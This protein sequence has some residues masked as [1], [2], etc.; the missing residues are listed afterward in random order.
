MRVRDFVAS[1][2]ARPPVL[3]V[4]VRPI[5]TQTTVTALAF[6]LLVAVA[7]AVLGQGLE[8][9]LWA[10]VGTGVL[11]GCLVLYLA[12]RLMLPRRLRLD[13]GWLRI[14]IRR[15]ETGRLSNFRIQRP[16][17]FPYVNLVADL[18]VDGRDP[19]SDGIPTVAL[20]IQMTERDAEALRTMVLAVLTARAA[21]SPS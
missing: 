15:W 3:D 17:G 14:G 21:G 1:S 10:V 16:P 4:V 9:A 8:Q 20:G 5:V 2:D 13:R 19:M 11:L 6:I 12:T 7:L 18:W